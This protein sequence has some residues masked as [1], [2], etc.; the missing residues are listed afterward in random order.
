MSNLQ[1]IRLVIGETQEMNVHFP[2]HP[3]KA[4]YA[5]RSDSGNLLLYSDRSDFACPVNRAMPGRVPAQVSPN[6]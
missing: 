4:A 2:P 3:L 1:D 5:F 6:L